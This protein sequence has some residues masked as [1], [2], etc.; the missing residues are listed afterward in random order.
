[1]ASRKLISEFS[2]EEIDIDIDTMEHKASEGSVELDI[3]LD[4]AQDD[5]LIISS[6]VLK[7]NFNEYHYAPLGRSKR[8]AK[9]MFEQPQNSVSSQQEQESFV[10]E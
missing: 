3:D 10:D 9:L 2:E 6:N 1:M 4:E 8:P 5:Q 7:L